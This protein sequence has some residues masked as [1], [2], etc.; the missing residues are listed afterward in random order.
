[1]G[2]TIAV[3]LPREEIQG[4]FEGLDDTGA[5]VLRLADGS[6]R[7]ISAGDVFFP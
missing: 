3:R 5:L 4:L 1:L 2:E 7:T 6:A